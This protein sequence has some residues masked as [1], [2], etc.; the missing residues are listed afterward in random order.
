MRISDWSSDV[1]SSDLRCR[2]GRGTRSHGPAQG[3][4]EPGRTAGTPQRAGARWRGGVALPALAFGRGAQGRSEEGSVGKECDSTCRM[5]WA[6]YHK[7]TQNKIKKQI[8][9]T[10]K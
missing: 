2:S 7:K 10:D 5:R 8:V 1:C 3:D 4:Q 9:K 6:R